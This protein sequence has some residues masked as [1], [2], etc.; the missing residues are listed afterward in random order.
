MVVYKRFF[1]VRKLKDRCPGRCEI[2]KRKN[3]EI[4][5]VQLSKNVSIKHVDLKRRI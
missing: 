3:T 4:V 2:K 5:K 1:G